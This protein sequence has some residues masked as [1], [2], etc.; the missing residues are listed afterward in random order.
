MSRVNYRKSP[1]KYKSCHTPKSHMQ[2]FEMLWNDGTWIG[3]LDKHDEKIRQRRTSRRK[4]NS[5][6]HLED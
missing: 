4:G 2:N 5:S 3:G 6:K 1:K